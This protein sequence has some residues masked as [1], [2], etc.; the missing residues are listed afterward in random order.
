MKPYKFLLEKRDNVSCIS[1]H[2]IKSRKKKYLKKK[3]RNLKS[4]IYGSRI[5]R[6]G[7]VRRKKKC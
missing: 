7:T 4:V 6:R 1:A 5:F 2:F 3:E